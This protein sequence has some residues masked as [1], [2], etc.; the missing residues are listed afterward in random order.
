MYR[1]LCT[2]LLCTTKYSYAGV[3]DLA[4]IVQEYENEILGRAVGFSGRPGVP[5]EDKVVAATDVGR[6]EEVHF[7]DSNLKLGQVAGVAVNIFDDPVVFH[8]GDQVWGKDTFLK[9]NVFKDQSKSPIS[10]NTILIVDQ[11]TGKVKSEMGSNQFYMPHGIT[12]DADN[13]I[14]VTDAALHQVMMFPWNSTTPSVVIG[15][16]FVPGSD[17]SHFCKP[18]SVVVSKSGNVYIAD[19]YCNKRVV[20]FDTKGRYLTEIHGD[21]N[22]VHSLAL[23]QEE[24]TLCIA[25]REGGRVDCVGAGLN[26]PQFLGSKIVEADNLGRVFGIA[27]RGSA[28]LAVTGPGPKTKAD[29]L[30]LDLVEMGKV[31][32]TWGKDLINPHAVAVSREGDTVYVAEIGPNR[33]RKFEVVA[34]E[35]NIFDHEFT[36]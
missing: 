33:L 28:L 23:F 1:L 17:Q 32:D 2:V 5:D 10:A 7:W 20:V 22:V 26:H 8:R 14:W 36:A 31:V 6:P 19:G 35:D 12:V 11:F 3:L 18:T 13:N 15:E 30:T 25:D 16:K 24:D 29:G 27:G 9:N 21:W 34:P 4:Q